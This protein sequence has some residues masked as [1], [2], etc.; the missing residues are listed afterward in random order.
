MKNYF[1]CFLVAFAILKADSNINVTG[2]FRYRTDN[3]NN[4]SYSN[5]GEN[6]DT[7]LRSRLNFDFNQFENAKVILQFQDT[8][9][10]GE[11]LNT[12][13]NDSNDNIS[14]HQG[15]VYIDN[16]FEYPIALKLGRY[17]VDYGSGRWFS[18]YDWDKVGRIFDGATITYHKPTFSFDLFNFK[19]S[20]LNLNPEIGNKRV[21]GL[22]FNYH[23]KTHLMNFTLINDFD[24]LTNRSTY[25]LYHLEKIGEIISVEYQYSL[26][27]GTINQI[28]Q[29]ATAYSL[30]LLF[31]EE[32]FN[33][34][35]GYDF[36]S[37]D[38]PSTDNK[39]EAFTQL[40]GDDHKFYGYMGYYTD[41]SSNVNHSGLTDFH[42]GTSVTTYFSLDI[43]LSL[44]IFQSDYDYD[45]DIF[46]N[47]IDLE[48]IKK[49]NENLT[50]TLGY[51]H[52]TKGIYF[53]LPASYGESKSTWAYFMTTVKM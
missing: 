18:G 31:E 39:N 20:D 42:F 52:F 41:L 4:Y 49:Y 21:T 15:Y 19:L 16:L 28:K 46:G 53:P 34:S 37:G 26:Q 11:G 14:L 17:E 35:I 8:K 51:A 25:D 22:N 6:N 12:S 40:Y 33:F 1:I 29:K 10:F 47:E 5:L 36:L 43:D 2:E 48:V 24:K 7:Y 38:D 32:L 30:N 50:F 45:N 23:Y 27:R 44:H 3:W 13:S 9:M